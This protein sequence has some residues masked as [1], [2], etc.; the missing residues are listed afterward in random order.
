M[1]ICSVY[2]ESIAGAVA[3][4]TVE[5]RAAAAFVLTKAPIVS[6]VDEKATEAELGRNVINIALRQS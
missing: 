1:T 5:G 2:A 6:V 3:G 4:E